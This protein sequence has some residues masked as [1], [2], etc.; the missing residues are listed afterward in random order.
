MISHYTSLMSLFTTG[1]DPDSVNM[2]N[3]FSNVLCSFFSREES[4]DGEEF[5]FS[6]T[7][8]WTGGRT[9]LERMCR[10]GDKKTRLLCRPID[11]GLYRYISIVHL[12]S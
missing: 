3:F 8:W 5:E 12:C 10:R 7:M 9:E 11:K 1:P 2:M 4:R 6:T